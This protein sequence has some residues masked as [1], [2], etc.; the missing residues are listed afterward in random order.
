MKTEIKALYRKDPKLARR[1]AS[2]LG[3]KILVNS[4]SKAV[5]YLNPVEENGASDIMDD[6]LIPAINSL[7]KLL[8]DTESNWELQ[9][10]TR[11]ILK[12]AQKLRKKILS[13]GSK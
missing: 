13:G 3:Y 11:N 10:D 6:T 1:V 8:E 4:S 12:D 2:A 9:R 7:F 5:E